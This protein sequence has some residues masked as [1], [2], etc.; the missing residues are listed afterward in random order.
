MSSERVFD[1]AIPRADE[2]RVRDLERSAAAA[3]ERHRRAPI[4][5]RTEANRLEH[6]R[7]AIDEI[8]FAELDRVLRGEPTREV[9][10]LTVRLV[11]PFA[12]GTT[13][14]PPSRRPQPP[15]AMFRSEIER[16]SPRKAVEERFASQL[17]LA[18]GEVKEAG[19]VEAINLGEIPNRV[20]SETL[21]QFFARVAGSAPVDAPVIYRD[22][23]VAR[24]LRLRS[25][26]I[27]DRVPEDGRQSLAVT[28][29]S[30][31]HMEMD[32]EVEGAWLRNREI[33]L[34]RPA[35]QTD[36]LVYLQSQQQ[37]AALAVDEPVELH[38]YQT[39]LPP[40][41]VGF[42]RALVDHHLHGRG[43]NIAVIP[44]YFEGDGRYSPGTPW[45]FAP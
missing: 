26:E 32:V 21:R 4:G 2:Q 9:A 27:A 18:V 31:R 8:A 19:S 13:I 14:A 12:P 25:I 30:I 41:N 28:L 35:G 11:W 43:C 5:D 34:R 20:L 39:G 10:D 15:A 24:P 7:A 6:I 42:Y 22:G 16:P 29:L 36:E 37:F 40:A 45:V 3:L 38:L 44:W 17:R 1:V 23:S 33:S